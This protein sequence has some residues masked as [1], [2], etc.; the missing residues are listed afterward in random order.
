MKRACFKG[1]KS[2]LYSRMRNEKIVAIAI[3]LIAAILFA[4][5]CGPYVWVSVYSTFFGQRDIV[6]T[7][8]EIA[9]NATDVTVVLNRIANWLNANITYD[10][11]AVYFYPT[12]PFLLFRKVPPDP[13]WTMT[14]RRGACEEEAVLFSEMARLAGIEARTVYNPAEDHVWCEVLVNG[15]WTPFDPGLP[16][17]ERLNN[18]GFYERPEPNGW[19]K[20]LSYVYFIGPD[21]KENDITKIYTGTGRLIVKV[22][23]DGQPVQDVRV[24]VESTFLMEKYPSSYSQP[25][26]CSENHTD[27]SGSCT[28][29]VGGNNYTVVAEFGTL[30]GYRNQINTSLKENNE[31]SVTLSDFSLLVPAGD[32][33][34]ILTI[35]LILAVLVIGAVLMYRNLK[36]SKKRSWKDHA[37]EAQ[38]E[39]TPSA[40]YGQKA[41]GL[42]AE[43]KGSIDVDKGTSA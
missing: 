28:F 27:N 19:G 5:F 31:M 39:I 40:R 1:E 36:T 37:D 9:S 13:A 22:E 41:V 16:E 32:I 18:P 14:V 38:N 11:Q 17:D 23:K 2:N 8:R 4:F 29:D 15:S 12:P 43:P 10:A 7:T 3:V 25:Q 35:I 30:F 20:E 26:F 42:S 6:N 33:L 34:T 21:G 24:M